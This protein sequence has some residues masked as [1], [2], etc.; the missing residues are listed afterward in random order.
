MIERKLI[1]QRLAGED[2][3]HSGLE[4]SRRVVIGEIVDE[5]FDGTATRWGLVVAPA[6]AHRTRP[7]GFGVLARAS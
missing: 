2:D 7:A 5:L 3:A 1:S 6:S 4:C